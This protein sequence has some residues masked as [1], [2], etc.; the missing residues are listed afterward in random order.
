M[1]HKEISFL[2]FFRVLLKNYLVITLTTVL[3]IG[4]AVYVLMTTPDMFRSTAIIMPASSSN[5][6]INAGGL[7]GLVAQSTL[8]SS[9]NRTKAYLDSYTLAERVY[10]R[11]K[12]EILTN[13]FSENWDPQGQ[14]WLNLA[15]APD[16]FEIVSTV[17]GSMTFVIETSYEDAISI[18][19]DWGDPKLAKRVVETYVEELEGLLNDYDSRIAKKERSFYLEQFMDTQKTLLGVQMV[20]RNLMDA[21]GFKTSNSRVDVKL[22]EDRILDVYNDRENQKEA[23]PEDVIKDVPIEVLLDYLTARK[24]ALQAMGGQIE[25]QY[26]MR[27]IESKQDHL[28]FHV[29]DQPRV[30]LSRFKPNKRVILTMGTLFGIV[31]G[32]ILAVLRDVFQL[33]EKFFGVLKFGGNAS[34][35]TV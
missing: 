9:S 21:Y 15:E 28:L 20:S 4:G 33:E 31:A 7:L 10:T 22:S 26:H 1:N 34:E 12:N 24:D 18:T 3:G 16:E 35:S 14:K 11:L 13:L 17:K 2:D 6:G 30:P 29:V 5:P 19:S 32:C 23:S 25:Q 8:A 27:R